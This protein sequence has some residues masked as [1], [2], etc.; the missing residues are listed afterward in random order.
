[1]NVGIFKNTTY[2][3]YFWQNTTRPIQILSAVLIVSLASR[4]QIYAMGNPIPWT[5]QPQAWLL[6]LSFMP[7][8]LRLPTV[9]L[10][11]S[12]AFT[13]LPV[14]ASPNSL[15]IAAWIGPT[16]GYLWSYGVLAVCLPKLSWRHHPGIILTTW[17]I[18]NSMILM[19]GWL[20]LSM[21]CGMQAAWMLGVE[22]F[23]RIDFLKTIGMWL[24]SR[25]LVRSYAF[26]QK[27]GSLF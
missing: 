16:A 24:C 9:W 7:V 3:S 10:W 23:W 6:I 25:M 21:S 8:D 26:Y 20:F 13:G 12:A 22:P 15:G 27:N 11:Y 4:I 18:G 17:L 2:L 5:L 1:M 19:M 14:L